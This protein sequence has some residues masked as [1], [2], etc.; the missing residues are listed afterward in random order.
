MR[1]VVHRAPR[2]AAT[3]FASGLLLS[4]FL[5]RYNINV[6]GVIAVLAEAR[7]PASQRGD[8]SPAVIKD[9]VYK[10]AGGRP[11]CLDL[12]PP[13]KRYFTKTPSV[14][15]IGGSLDSGGM[16]DVTANEWTKLI[17][18]SGLALISVEYRPATGGAVFPVQPEDCADAV[19]FMAM[20]ADEYGLD[21]KRFCLM[22]VGDGGYLALLTA[23]T[24]GRYATE[25][26]GSEP[27]SVKC[28]VSL[29]GT[30]DLLDLEGLTG[31][32]RERAE[33]LYRDYIG[34]PAGALQERYRQASPLYQIR[35]GA[36]P[37]FLA[38]SA[39]KDPIPFSQAQRFYQS[40]L[41]KGLDVTLVKAETQGFYPT[42]GNAFLPASK[43]LIGAL[44]G[45]LAKKLIFN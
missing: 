12:Y 5:I 32:A 31:K 6:P 18:G 7:T 13:E 2:A 27:F 24:G 11:L 22:G 33:R 9:V 39:A 19:R 23:L 38:H 35:A 25:G 21:K 1:R 30:T 14:F 29:C 41:K 16:P 8:Y 45:F 26:L 34:G 42:D 4:A 17:L 15:F 20:H 43:E 37:V 36:P 44:K 3:L 10:T 40:A 28:A